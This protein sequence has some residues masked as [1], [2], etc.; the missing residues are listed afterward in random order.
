MRPISASEG[1]RCAAADLGYCRHPVCTDL[2]NFPLVV[3][4]ELLSKRF[5]LDKPS[6]FD[7]D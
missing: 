5:S 2:E 4:W 6:E 7:R 1:L 3:G